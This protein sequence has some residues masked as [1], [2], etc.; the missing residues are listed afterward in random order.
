M[1]LQK[2]IERAVDKNQLKLEGG[3][4]YWRKY[5]IHIVELVWAR[6]LWNGYEIHVYDGKD[7]RHL[8]SVMI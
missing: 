5:F 3:E 4:R 1:D 6:N 8:G 2:Y 7:K